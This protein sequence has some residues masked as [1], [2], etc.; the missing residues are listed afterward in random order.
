MRLTPY[1]DTVGK[2]TIGVGRNL[3]DV[4]ITDAEARFLLE[5]DIAR[6]VAD[7]ELRVEHP[8]VAW[9]QAFHLPADQGI[10]EAVILVQDVPETLAFGLRHVTKRRRIRVAQ[11]SVSHRIDAWKP[12][13]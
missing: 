3:D 8:L 9:A 13:G 12:G 1:R 2:L 7:L 10:H 6:T 5:N 11:E 4:G